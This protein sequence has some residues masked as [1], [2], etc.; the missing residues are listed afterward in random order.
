MLSRE[1]RWKA[2]GRGKR[3]L[4]LGFSFGHILRQKLLTRSGLPHPRHTTEW[5][6][7]LGTHFL[8]AHPRLGAVPKA[9][10]TTPRSPLPKK[11]H[12]VGLAPEERVRTAGSGLSLCTVWRHSGPRRRLAYIH[13][14]P[15]ILHLPK[16]GSFLYHNTWPQAHLYKLAVFGN[17]TK[18]QSTEKNWDLFLVKPNNWFE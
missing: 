6:P 10:L 13:S 9:L 12:E 14:V 18:N 8:S 5:Q 1:Q 3:V 4:P 15:R 7:R 11:P 2:Q 17:R 16:E